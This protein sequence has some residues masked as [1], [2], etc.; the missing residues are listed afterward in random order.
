MDLLLDTVNRFMKLLGRSGLKESDVD[1]FLRHPAKA[2]EWVKMYLQEK[3]LR[4][5]YDDDSPIAFDGQVWA[6]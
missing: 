4:G 1:Y 3:E 5:I 6:I 2:A